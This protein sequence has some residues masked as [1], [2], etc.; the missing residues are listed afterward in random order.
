MIVPALIL[1]RHTTIARAERP[2]LKALRWR[3]DATDDYLVRAPLGVCRALASNCHGPA[4]TDATATGGKI[5]VHQRARCMSGESLVA[6]NRYSITEVENET[7]GPLPGC[8]RRPNGRTEQ[9]RFGVRHFT[10]GM[11]QDV[12]ASTTQLPLVAINDC[13]GYAGCDGP[14]TAAATAAK[15]PVSS[16]WKRCSSVMVESTARRM[17]SIP[18][19]SI[20][21]WRLA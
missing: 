9:H 13:S 3:V 12:Y 1:F 2:T 7:A 11:A 15:A 21:N 18:F 4:S 17:P 10:S 16:M 19:S 14:V 20:S 8:C 6:V 5:R